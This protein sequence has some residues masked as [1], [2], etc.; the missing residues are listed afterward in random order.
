M[1]KIFCGVVIFLLIVFGNLHFCFSSDNDEIIRQNLDD[2]EFNEID[3]I[4]ENSEYGKDFDIRKTAEKFISG[5]L[6]LSAKGIINYC[7]KSIFN[8]VY[9]NIDIIR[10]VLIICVLSAVIKNLTNS[11]QG[12]ETGELGFY[13]TYIVMVILLF[14][15]FSICISIMKETVFEISE[16]MKASTPLIIGVLVMSGCSTSAYL[17]SPVIL[18]ASEIIIMLVE[19]VI[20]PLIIIASVMQIVNYLSE[21]EVLSNFS[22]LI[23]NCVSWVVK[24][25]AIIFMGILSLQRLGGGSVNML[26]N[27]TAK[28]AV[29]M[30]P[31]VG[32]V[33]SGTIDSFF[34]FAGVV[35]TG[36]G[37]AI[38][39]GIIILCSV[40]IIKIIAIIFI[41][42]FTASLVQPICDKRIVGCI[43]NMGKY[44][45]VILSIVVMTSVVF[46]FSVIMIISASGM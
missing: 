35:K 46:I 21:R 30:V 28:Y 3:E 18:S 45:G 17:F 14:S 9:E 27:K 11:L 32:D 8:E 24:G 39:L 15:S 5:E 6:E 43:D 40:P 31:V 37:A 20:V 34:Y 36:V 12:K 13:V 2:L 23:K 38:I 44:A 22:N 42:K 1:K 25:C 41:Y 29:N 16:I 33:F 7:F 4:F 10:N 26:F 19:N